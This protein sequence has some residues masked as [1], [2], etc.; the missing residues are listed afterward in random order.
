MP[1]DL[2]LN[3]CETRLP[4]KWVETTLDRF[5]GPALDLSTSNE[6][7]QVGVRQGVLRYEILGLTAHSQYLARAVRDPAANFSKKTLWTF[8]R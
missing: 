4:H 7:C 5:I 2:L 3:N 8:R 1:N 6:A